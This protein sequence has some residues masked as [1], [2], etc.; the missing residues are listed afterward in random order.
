[1]A[2]AGVVA[3][4]LAAGC[5]S[6]GGG[7]GGT[8][9]GPVTITIAEN[10]GTEQNATALKNLAAAF[11]T[12]HPNVTVKIQPQNGDNYFALLQKDAISKSGPDLAVMWTGLFTLQYK[13]FLTNLKGEIPAADLARVDPNALKWTSDGFN[14]A[15][16]PY[17]IPPR[18]ASPRCRPTGA[19]S[20]PPAPS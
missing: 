3:A 14:P 1:M 19:S 5:S 15:N 12:L 18:P 10:Y 6:S 9:S 13:S 20:T 11:H 4:L 8:S 7:S 17:V 16:G 2:A